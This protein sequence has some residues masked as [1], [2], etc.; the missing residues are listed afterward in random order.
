[1]PAPRVP[2]VRRHVGSALTANFIVP[3]TIAVQI[4]VATTD[5]D[6]LSEQL[7]VRWGD[8]AQ[9]I[10]I[11][12]VIQSNV[13]RVHIIEAPAGPVTINYTASVTPSEPDPSL[14]RPATPSGYDDALLTALR[15]SRYCPSDVLAPFAMTELGEFANSDGLVSAAVEWVF[16]RLEYGF[17]SSGFTDT[18][19]DTLLAGRGVCRDFA[20]L[21]ITL[22]RAL[23]VPARFVSVY[24]P[25]LGPMDF[26]AVVEVW[27]GGRWEIVDPT[28]LAPRS[29]LVRIA[30]G[31]DAAD[32]AFVMTLVGDVELVASEV[33]AVIDG[34]L[35]LDDHRGAATLA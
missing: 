5:G 9:P 13:G 33:F 26:H 24:A 2:G 16:D 4:A 12:D 3:S 17:G 7:D 31:R 27:H 20:H 23:G 32:T 25:G 35:P 10:T 34:D 14:A 15:Q 21:T 11:T 18:A 19:I 28:R 1:V 29:A 30:T 22:L 8:D 6:D